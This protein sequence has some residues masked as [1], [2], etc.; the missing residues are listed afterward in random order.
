MTESVVFAHAIFEKAR[1]LLPVRTASLDEYSIPAKTNIVF[2]RERVACVTC[3]SIKWRMECDIGKKGFGRDIKY[4][5][6][7]IINPDTGYRKFLSCAYVES[8]V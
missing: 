4:N 8:I 2:R 3:H 1:R 6:A 7:E 5:R